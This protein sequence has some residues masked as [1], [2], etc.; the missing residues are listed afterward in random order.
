MSGK[1]PPNAN[2]TIRRIQIVYYQSGVGVGDDFQGNADFGDNYEKLRGTAT[3]GKIRDAYNFIAQNYT[4]GDRI[5]LF[6]FSRGAYTARKVAGLI[7]TLGLLNRREMGRFFH[8]WSA[9][10]RNDPKVEIIPGQHATI[11]F[12]GVWD[13][14]G[15]VYED[16]VT[17]KLKINALTLVDSDLPEG[18]KVARHA[19]SYHENRTEFLPTPFANYNPKRDVKQVWFPGVHSDVG[20]SYNEHLIADI[21]LCWMAGEAINTGLTIDEDFLLD[22]FTMIREPNPEL[23]IHFER[24]SK[25]ALSLLTVDRMATLVKTPNSKEVLLGNMESNFLYHPS[26]WAEIRET[27]KGISYKAFPSRR[28][29]SGDPPRAPL[30]DFEKRYWD[31]CNWNALLPLPVMG[32]QRAPMARGSSPKLR[33]KLQSPSLSSSISIIQHPVEFEMVQDYVEDM[34]RS[35]IPAENAN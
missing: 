23:R 28:N 30:S 14:V 19:L 33:P 26:L 6:G 16:L 12:L 9:L 18:V 34:V 21:A 35:E 10:D 20:G 3:G 29:S 25:G 32:F 5:Y 11:D 8:Y 2:V 24:H 22:C 7:C 27:P 4:Q 15:S 13:T 31:T 17:P 1:I